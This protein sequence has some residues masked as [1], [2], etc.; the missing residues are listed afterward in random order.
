MFTFSM[1]CRADLCPPLTAGQIVQKCHEARIPHCLPRSWLKNFLPLLHR[2]TGGQ[3]TE[4]IMPEQ[5]DSTLTE[6]R[7]QSETPSPGTST[8]EEASP[9]ETR[10]I[11]QKFD[12]HLLTLFTVINLFSFIDRVNIGNARLLG[13]Q[14][15]LD[16]SGN[17]FNIA[18]TCLLV[19]YCVVELPSNILC[20]IIG[21]HIYIPCL[22]LGFGLITT[23]TALVTDRGE[24]YACRVLLGIFEGGISP[25]L[26]FM[27][28]LLSVS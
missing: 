22:V 21:G 23:C 17:R 14:D 6:S 25:G 3:A 5:K 28:S 16:L 11:I 18:L 24:L 15:D 19:T 10:R 13:L 9:S 2:T 26:V 20:K 7:G 4:S 12:L 8:P 27:L 1:H